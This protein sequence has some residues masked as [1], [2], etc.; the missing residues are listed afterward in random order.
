MAMEPSPLV[1]GDE[2]KIYQQLLE[3]EIKESPPPYQDFSK[4]DL[5]EKQKEEINAYWDKINEQVIQKIQQ[6]SKKPIELGKIKSI[7]EK[8]DEIKSLKEKQ[9]EYALNNPEQQRLNRISSTVNRMFKSHL[10][11]AEYFANR[12]NDQ[13]KNLWDQ[14]IIQD[15]KNIFQNYDYQVHYINLDDPN[16]QDV[17][18][19]SNAK[20]YKFK[21]RDNSRILSVV[22]YAPQKGISPK[23]LAIFNHGGQP[24]NWYFPGQM[25]PILTA[26]AGLNFAIACP[27]YRGGSPQNHLEDMTA[28]KDYF[29]K[30]NL[31]NPNQVILSGI[32]AGTTLNAKILGTPF[33]KELA[34]VFLHTGLYQSPGILDYILNLPPMLP[35]F[36]A[37][38][39]LDNLTSREATIKYI[40]A[41]QG[42]SKN[43]T[44]YLLSHGGHQLIE[45]IKK[46]NVPSILDPNQIE[47]PKYINGILEK[48]SKK[49]NSKE[50]MDYISH[51]VEFLDRIA[52][53]IEQSEP[54]KEPKD[55]LPTIKEILQHT[56]N[57]QEI[58]KKVSSSVIIKKNDILLNAPYT[59]SELQLK[60]LLGNN[61][62]ENNLEE[63]INRFLKKYDNEKV[64]IFEEY[65]K[66]HDSSMARE[67]RDKIIREQTVTNNE[68]KSLILK[69]LEKE[70]EQKGS[71]VLY[72]GT[73]SRAGFIYDVYT[74]IRNIFLLRP[75]KNAQEQVTRLRLLDDA[76]IKVINAE[77]FVEHMKSQEHKDTETLFNYLPGYQE[78]GIS[79]QWFLFGSYKY[80]F[81]S[82]FFR[83][84]RES[85]VSSNVNIQNILQS[86]FQKI[87]FENS[88]KLSSEFAEI[89]RT[90]VDPKD[91]R[92]LQFFISPDI[93]DEVTY[94]SETGGYPLELKSMEN[95]SV[96]FNPS[97]FFEKGLY[98]PEI[99]EE[100]LKKNRNN[101]KHQNK[102]DR[103]EFSKQK[104]GLRYVNSV[105]ARFL[106]IPKY[107][108]DPT[109]IQTVSYHLIPPREG[110]EKALQE[111]TKEVVET[112]L[113]LN[114]K[115]T[116]SMIQDKPPLV[117]LKE[118][119]AQGKGIQLQKEESPKTLY[120]LLSA[121]KFNQAK[122][123]IAEHPQDINTKIDPQGHTLLYQL[124]KDNKFK[125]AQ[126][127]IDYGADVNARDNMKYPIIYDLIDNGQFEAA[128]ILINNNAN[129][130][131]A[132]SPKSNSMI[133]NFIER[134]VNGDKFLQAKFLATAKKRGIQEDIQDPTLRD[135]II[136]N[137]WEDAYKRARDLIGDPKMMDEE[138]KQ[139]L[140]NAPTPEKLNQA[141]KLLEQG[142]RLDQKDD[143]ETP[144]LLQVFLKY[145]LDTA[146]WMMNHGA[147]ANVSTRGTPFLNKL[148][149]SLPEDKLIESIKLCLDY[150]AKPTQSIYTLLFDLGYFS[151][152][153]IIKERDP[154]YT[155]EY[156]Y[157]KLDQ[158]FVIENW[159]KE[160]KNKL[161]GLVQIGIDL[162]NL[163]FRNLSLTFYMAGEERWDNFFWLL[164]QGVNINYKENKKLENKDIQLNSMPLLDW[165]IFTKKISI[166]KILP[167]LDNLIKYGLNINDV[168]EYG[169]SLFYNLVVWSDDFEEAKPLAEALLRKGAII[170]TTSYHMESL[171][172]Y[173][174]SQDRFQKDPQAI[175][176]AQWFISKG[177]DINAITSN[178][179]SILNRL[180]LEN[181]TKAIEFL[182]AQPSLKPLNFNNM[183]NYFNAL[184]TRSIKKAIENNDWST[185]DLMFQKGANI[186][187]QVD[188]ENNKVD[189]LQYFTLTKEI[190]IENKIST[191]NKLIS[192]GI[193][194][195]FLNIKKKFNALSLLIDENGNNI[196]LID[197]VGKHLL[198]K[199]ANID[200]PVGIYGEPILYIL[201]KEKRFDVFSQRIHWLIENN[202][203]INA[204]L[205]TGLSIFDSVVKNG[206]QL[207]RDLLLSQKSQSIQINPYMS[208]KAKDILFL[209]YIKTEQWE[210]LSD[211]R[212]NP[213]VPES[214]I[215]FP[216]GI[217]EKVVQEIKDK[218]IQK[219]IIAKLI[220]LGASIHEKINGLS[221][222]EWISLQDDHFNRDLLLVLLKRGVNLYDIG[223]MQTILSKPEIVIILKKYCSERNINFNHIIVSLYCQGLKDKDT[224]IGNLLRY[225]KKDPDYE[226]KYLPLILNTVTSFQDSNLLLR[227]INEFR[228]ILPKNRQKEIK[229]HIILQSLSRGEKHIVESLV[230]AT[231]ESINILDELKN[232]IINDRREEA[233]GLVVN[234]QK[235]RRQINQE[236]SDILM[237]DSPNWKAEAEAAIKKNPHRDIIEDKTVH[238]KTYS[239]NLLF[240]LINYGEIEKAK[241]LI[242][243]GANV[244]ALTGENSYP[245]LLEIIKT[246]KD[247]S[248]Q[249]YAQFLIDN[250]ANINRSWKNGN[251]ELSLLYVVLLN[252]NHLDRAAWLIHQ[253]ANINSQEGY[254]PVLLSVLLNTNDT[255]IKRYI[256]FLKEQG[257]DMNLKLT[258]NNNMSILTF[259]L[260]K[261]M[262]DRSILLLENGA[263]FDSR[264]KDKMTVNGR[265]IENYI[266]STNR[267]ELMQLLGTMQ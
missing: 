58:K 87:G 107:M 134:D 227:A 95:A 205:P 208:Q 93:I 82:T 198:S 59:L 48:A 191:I 52:Y 102:T 30:H 100:T 156:F 258:A 160:D 116:L 261:E 162:N 186:N 111:R 106:M 188:F 42:I 153:N 37:S 179:Q 7:K 27:N 32:S 46:E 131:L 67:Q 215:I 117:K 49:Y 151:L 45:S 196:E 219:R 140:L 260:L 40:E 143:N 29:T 105:E 264:D 263:I 253:G 73:D 114:L 158:L 47:D 71:Y 126:W 101:F 254:D 69:I 169:N 125:A 237:G 213:K 108:D 242:E 161:L 259:M 21:Y 64:Q 201:L 199:G 203:N 89:Y 83:Y 239:V 176:R 35:I 88:E 174:L 14:L 16:F 56:N 94:L 6:L 135:F 220:D 132:V 251:I 86:F 104:M 136:N 68:L 77:D 9:N 265:T 209:H 163:I 267:P 74:A 17:D 145:D 60:I 127:L 36:I 194:V 90:Y 210:K 12:P 225:L 175:I 223:Y 172:Y 92:L 222:L 10:I 33:A 20:D 212:E 193:D 141:E 256:Q 187:C 109:K 185:V 5:S 241:W 189:L 181:N 122:L 123:L 228:D 78:M 51:L 8:R 128:Q 184:L 183:N 177:V 13:N 146:R 207:S 11:V 224:N 247:E 54:E 96:S 243:N 226:L 178:G 171:L 217:L 231:E 234:L 25:N 63:N 53:P 130:R 230:S 165:L 248:Y 250:G 41:L 167:H 43:L 211:F 121:G 200:Q 119:I 129:L 214:N 85:S 180:L 182:L 257:A 75:L 232:H 1:Q 147:D 28:V 124:L 235:I 195:N 79:A 149:L 137:A 221:L 155:E 150:G 99:F 19:L 118:Y 262:T 139:I 154:N 3:N 18:H 166:K 38:G 197:K 34:G 144:L 55:F 204:I 98:N 84:F 115:P 159:K 157:Q 170:Q 81:N 148:I 255:Y 206:L 2:E 110:Y 66:K 252:P 246:F 266:R 173:Y 113:N 164:E 61:Y 218:D 236:L 240:K 80:W 65:L 23:P 50:M 62:V 190:S 192:Y 57:I 97:S 168:D 31:I 233:K 24:N 91:G 244:D 202:A 44:Y 15:R 72:H 138:V 245:I 22:Y 26:F 238:G 120:D 229:T 152:I 133:I 4:D 112:W 39:E 216:R 76:L 103:E 249:R 142:A 70:Q